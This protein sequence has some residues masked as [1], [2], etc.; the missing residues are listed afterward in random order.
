MSR[1]EEI[2]A[3]T[4][5]EA[6]A[7]SKPVVSTCVGGIPEFVSDGLTGFLVPPAYSDAISEKILVLLNDAEM[8]SMTGKMG[9]KV[10]ERDFDL[11][12]NVSGLVK[13]YCLI[14]RP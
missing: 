6:M 7:C 14:S 5:A 4:I 2:F 12:K 11:K 3:W 1:R 10:P 8:R 13:F 9:R